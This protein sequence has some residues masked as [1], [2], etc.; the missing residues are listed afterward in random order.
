MIEVRNLSY[1]YAGAATSALTHIQFNTEPGSATAL[2]GPNGAGKT[3]LVSLLAGILPLQQGQILIDGLDART[4]RREIQ[5]FSSLVTQ[6]YAFYPRLSCLE[7]LT[8][9]ASIHGLKGQQRR[10]RIDEAVE[11]CSLHQALGKRASQCSGGVKRRLN[12]AIALLNR[13]RLLILDEPTVG[14]DPQSRQYIIERLRQLQQQGVSLLYTSHMLDEV[15]R[16]CQHLAVIDHGQ[17]KLNDS[18]LNALEKRSTRTLSIR[19]PAHLES[20]LREIAQ[21]ND[22]DAYGQAIWRVSPDQVQQQ[23]QALLALLEQH[24]IPFQQFSVGSHQLE[25]LFIS[26]TDQQLRD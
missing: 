17:L 7:N 6:E 15:Q 11:F 21:P 24:A 22:I 4:Q 2:L 18:M 1:R 19:V 14:V 5:R 8:F 3:T 9:F 12:L 26:L 16:L 13:P 20:K 10:A 25:E 23:T